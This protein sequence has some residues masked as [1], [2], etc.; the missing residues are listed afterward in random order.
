MN[1][2]NISRSVQDL[3]NVL[4]AATQQ[5]TGLAEKLVKI[6]AQN[7]INENQLETMGNLVDTYA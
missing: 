4:L 1:A 5:S 7:T 3:T 6:N 2:A